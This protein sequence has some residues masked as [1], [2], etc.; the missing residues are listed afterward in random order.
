MS[1]ETK[2]RG[3]PFHS[4][5]FG[6]LALIGLFFATSAISTACEPG[7]RNDESVRTEATALV[8]LGQGAVPAPGPDEVPF[9]SRISAGARAP[10]PQLVAQFDEQSGEILAPNV[11]HEPAQWDSAGIAQFPLSRY[12]SAIAAGAIIVAADVIGPTNY[13]IEGM[14]RVRFMRAGLR[15]VTVLFGA[16]PDVTPDSMIFLLGDH[17]LG[18]HAGGRYILA[19][20][21]RQD[22]TWMPAESLAPTV[23]GGSVPELQTSVV[24]VASEIVRVCGGAP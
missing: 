14:E 23:Q 16:Q 22:G 19:L 11:S 5:R 13:R 24:D 17:G 4:Q 15:S 1:N 2:L 21:H 9:A 6:K 7:C 20:S 12:C 18:V 8:S 3:K 10:Q